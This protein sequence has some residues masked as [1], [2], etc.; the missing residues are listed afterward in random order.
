MYSACIASPQLGI[1]V[2][3][4]L[5]SGSLRPS[6]SLSKFNVGTL[7]PIDHHGPFRSHHAG[8][9][10]SHD[11][12]VLVGG[13]D[14]HGRARD[15]HVLDLNSI[16]WSIYT[17]L[18]GPP[19]MVGPN[20][21]PC[22]PPVGLSGHS[23]TRINDQCLLIIGREGGIKTQRRFTSIFYLWLDHTQQTYFYAEG[24]QNVDSRSGHSAL[25]LSRS[26]L[27]LFGGRKNDPVQILDIVTQ[28]LGL[29][30]H[31]EILN[32]IQELEPKASKLYGL[33]YHAWIRLAPRVFLVH[34]GQNFKSIHNQSSDLLLLQFFERSN[35]PLVFIVPYQDVRA[36]YG[37][38]LI[39]QGSELFLIHGSSCQPLKLG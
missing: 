7:T 23:V 10:L 31:P 32:R 17:L 21:V 38:Q 24:S 11:R 3:G 22:E 27:A 36:Q 20:C 19:K 26:E 35:N 9:L 39:A 6:N 13:W 15:V 14:G 34:G 33:R 8:T 29:S 12:W 25:V 5:I 18:T 16:T 2:H 28:E 37:H 4:G 30:S 1:F